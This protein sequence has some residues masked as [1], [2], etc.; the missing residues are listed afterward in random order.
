M[1]CARG[2]FLL[3]AMAAVSLTVV[4]VFAFLKAVEL[5]RNE[6]SS[7][8][9]P[10]LAREAALYGLRHAQEEL[11]KDYHREAVATLDAPGRAAFRAAAQPLSIE[12]DW[13]DAS[14]ERVL[15]Q[16]DVAME[17]R[18]SRPLWEERMFRLGTHVDMLYRLDRDW[19]YVAGR[20][21]WF[22][23][24]FRNR[25]AAGA[26]TLPAPVPFPWDDGADADGT[27]PG[28]QESGTLSADIQSPLAF[29]GA[30]NRIAAAGGATEARA[31]RRY[32]RYR[33][34]YAVV[35]RDLDGTILINPDPDLDWRSFTR[36]DPRTYADPT[37]RM[38]AR[39]MHLVPAVACALL[40]FNKGMDSGAFGKVPN[41][42]Q[43]IFMGRGNGRNFARSA[44]PLDGS[45]VDIAPRTFPLMY[46]TVA[47]LRAHGD[48]FG[49]TGTGGRLYDFDGVTASEAG[50]RQVP[51]SDNRTYEER[52]TGLMLTGPQ[53]SPYNLC[54][55]ATCLTSV[56][57]W[58]PTPT[59]LLM[60]CS[61]FGRGLSG[62]SLA[63]RL[64]SSGPYDGWTSTP[65]KV[66]LLTAPPAVIRALLYAYLPSGVVRD[67][68]FRDLFNET[69][70][71]AFAY[72]APQGSSP[73]Y[74]DYHASDTRSAAQRYPGPLLENGG[75]VTDVLGR[76]IAVSTLQPVLD[77]YLYTSIVHTGIS[78]DLMP[79][80]ARDSFWNDI[81]MAFSNAVGVAKRAHMRYPFTKFHGSKWG[82]DPPYQI[83]VTP[84]TDDAAV[85]GEASAK[86]AGTGDFDRLFLACLGVDMDRQGPGANTAPYDVTSYLWAGEVP[87]SGTV[88]EGR[89]DYLTAV[90]NTTAARETIRSLFRTG[91]LT[92]DQSSVMELVLNDFRLSFFA[93]D[94]A[95]TAAF[96]PL[97]FNG[98]GYA[99]CSAYRSD[100]ASA[101]KDLARI[102]LGIGQ[103][104]AADSDGRGEWSIADILRNPGDG[105]R[106]V[107]F[108]ISG[109][110]YVGRSR[111]W[112]VTVRGEVY[113]NTLKR[114]VAN[115]T[116][117]S[118]VAIDPE[119]R[120]EAGAGAGRPIHQVL[121]QRWYF[122]RYG[123]LMGRE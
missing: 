29:D 36:A 39:H 62:K 123:A 97:D 110:L 40:T 58:A 69:H 10:M 88:A 25:T 17:T 49:P 6:A 79:A 71:D 76:D 87:A 44:L 56:D 113:D 11:V 114:P 19:F 84:A 12:G 94:P 14:S 54:R 48:G 78:A 89:S 85:V 60:A 18:I 112:D 4:M 80:A 74:P 32:A 86:V 92:A 27:H 53:A 9:F 101:R 103:E 75:G 41:L 115:A 83:T 70:S 13:G 52:A 66:N 7:A 91:R 50:G 37:Q 42:M 117:Q 109:C 23:V 8:A 98:D 45:A 120:I 81:I 30:W 35:A 15:D 104:S 121:F 38:V 116:L 106:I 55:V 82:A 96:R 2:S 34:R 1:R 102:A 20:G 22:E 61:P 16:V 5:Q 26:T 21:R 67:H 43:H 59:P 57:W 95:Y 3:F 119:G 24:E 90:K 77:P 105:Q 122:D 72:R 100:R 47:D 108:C 68:R 93:S 107:P 65:W 111:F 118:V 51:L 31:A 73:V 33:L 28:D 99:A 63:D 46:R 64:S